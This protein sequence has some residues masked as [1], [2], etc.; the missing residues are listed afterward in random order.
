[1][2]IADCI[3]VLIDFIFHL[4][5]I[6][7]GIGLFYG[8]FCLFAS[9]SNTPYNRETAIIFSTVSGVIWCIIGE[10]GLWMDEKREKK[11]DNV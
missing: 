9:E 10:I 5:F 7:L 11:K 3:S 8:M 4:L 6:A 2:R 1:M